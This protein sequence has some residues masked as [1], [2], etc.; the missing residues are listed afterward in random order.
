MKTY[1][2]LLNIGKDAPKE[3]IKRA[4]HK[5]AKQFHPDISNNHHLFIEILD[6]YKTLI[7]DDKRKIYNSSLKKFTL[8][9]GSFIPKSRVSFAVSLQDIARFKIYYPAKR[10]R[11]TG[12]FKPKGYDVCVQL[13]QSE[14]QGGS[15]VYIDIPAHVICPLCGGNRVHCTLC[16]YKGYVLKAVP[17]PV[18]IPKDLRDGDIFSVPIRELKIKEYVFFLIKELF[19]KI[20]IIG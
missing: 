17:F 13:T 6:A 12:G 15:V 5:L 1:Y 4:F 8:Q 20:K 2:E 7:D 9:K 18:S 14:L 3:D 16:S 19:V 10:K 11:R